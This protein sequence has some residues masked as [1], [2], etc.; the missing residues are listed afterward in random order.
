MVKKILLIIFLNAVVSFNGLIAQTWT[1]WYG[2]GSTA[3][4]SA[5]TDS[6]GNFW[7]GTMGDGLLVKKGSTWINYNQYNSELASNSVKSVAVASDGSIWAATDSGLCHSKGSGWEVFTDKNSSFEDIAIEKVAVGKNGEIWAIQWPGVHRYKNGT[8]TQYT[9]ATHS[10]YYNDYPITLGIDNNGVC[11]AGGYGYEMWSFDG[12]SWTTRKNLGLDT[13]EYVEIYSIAFDKN[14]V[15]HVGTLDH[16]VYKVKLDSTIQYLGG[17]MGF[18]LNQVNDLMFTNDGKLWIAGEGGGIAIYDGVNF[19]NQTP[20]QGLGSDRVACL[21]GN[22]SAIAAVNS[23]A[24]VSVFTAGTWEY[25]DPNKIGLFTA[26]GIY[27]MS[28]D[29]SNNVWMGGNAEIAKYDG[30][31]WTVYRSNGTGVPNDVVTA[32]KFDSKN[33]VWI[34]SYRGVAEFDQTANSWI[35][36]DIATA[37]LPS[38]YIYD[39]DIDTK[40]I[41]WL[42]TDSGLVKFDGMTVVNYNKASGRLIVDQVSTVFVDKNDKVWAGTWGGGLVSFDGTNWSKITQS[43]TGWASDYITSLSADKN[44]NL[45]VGT[46]GGYAVFDGATWTTV[47]SSSLPNKAEYIVDVSFDI[48]ND[49]WISTDLGVV[50]KLPTGDIL[51]VSPSKPLADN[52]TYQ[53]LS[54]GKDVWFACNRVLSRLTDAVTLRPAAVAEIE[55]IQLSISPNPIKDGNDLLL[56]IHGMDYGKNLEIQIVDVHGKIVKNIKI[57]GNDFE[58]NESI[59]ISTN[60]LSPGIYTVSINGISSGNKFLVIR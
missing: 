12:T 33:K 13:V 19:S 56:G 41:V 15:L 16:G 37:G 22:A 59:S 17:D 49:P 53:T 2:N 46:Y 21:T 45:W 32:I 26:S 3:I 43:S 6:S 39:M 44:G 40:D 35:N 36:Y 30:A 31:N 38:D 7:F 51:Y 23:E 18:Y 24:G 60:N 28:L 8:W 20:S 27:S 34:S 25:Y 14:N 58:T 11:W 52:F 48:N 4:T 42:A 54:Q 1:S 9:E 29:K 55:A 5:A 57:Q 10:G 47:S 50:H